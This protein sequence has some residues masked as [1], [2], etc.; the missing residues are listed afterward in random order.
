MTVPRR[1]GF[2]NGFRRG[3]RDVFLFLAAD[4]FFPLCALSSFSVLVCRGGFD[5]TMVVG[6]SLAGAIISKPKRA[7]TSSSSSRKVAFP[8]DQMTSS[9]ARIGFLTSSGDV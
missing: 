9:N 8:N 2:F 1:A 7:A 5:T 6:S 3:T 4:A